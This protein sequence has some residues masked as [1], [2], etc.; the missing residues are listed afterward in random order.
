MAS[1]VHLHCHSDYSL[2]DGASSVESLAA[3]A[4]EL[5]MDRLALTDHGNM[6]GAMKFLKACRGEE[7]APPLKPIIG[8]EVY[9]APGSRHEKTASGRASTRR[10][11]RKPRVTGTWCCWRGTRPATATSWPSARSATP[12]ASTT[13]PASTTSCSSAT[14]RG[15]SA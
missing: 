3:R 13:S 12:K 9:V 10:A 7:G 8:C 5:G 15:S 1:F 11:A 4:R 2:L 14:T 6:F